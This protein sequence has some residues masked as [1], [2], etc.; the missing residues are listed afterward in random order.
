[1]K[2]ATLTCLVVPVLTLAGMVHAEP[3][4][5]APGGPLDT[6]YG[7]ANVVEV[8]SDA[9]QL[10]TNPSGGAVAVE[11]MAKWASYKQVFGY[12]PGETGGTFVPVFY[13]S[14]NGY[15][16]GTPSAV[17]PEADTGSTFRFADD[18]CG[19]P[20]WSSQDADNSDGQDHMRTF[21]ITD[22]PSAGHFAICWEDL[23]CLGDRDH[24]DLIVEVSSGG[25]PVP[26]P[27]ALALIGIGG[28]GVLR[29]RRRK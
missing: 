3:I 6:L 20:L 29:R 21:R 22:G 10:W 27:A 1:M 9:D 18:P 25:A 7:L 15:L 12:L 8:P 23:P 13:V 26:E 11:A 2:A 16:S 19:A 17:L 24:Q 14:G 28:V 4:L 5:T